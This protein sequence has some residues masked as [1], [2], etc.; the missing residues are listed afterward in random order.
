MGM[1]TKTEHEG[2]ELERRAVKAHLKRSIKDADKISPK[3]GGPLVK[4]WLEGALKWVEGRCKRYRERK[5][6]L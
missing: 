1:R 3:D 4:L 6:G 2:A 5:G